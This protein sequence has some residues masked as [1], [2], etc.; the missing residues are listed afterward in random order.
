MSDDKLTQKHE[1]I[2]ASYPE[3]YERLLKELDFHTDDE[4]VK[5]FLLKFTVSSLLH[6]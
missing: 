4:N 3:G 2:Y 5:R 1:G 6:Y